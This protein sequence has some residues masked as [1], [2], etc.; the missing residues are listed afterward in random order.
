MITPR[1]R[2]SAIAFSGIFCR[3]IGSVLN[4]VAL[5]MGVTMSLDRIMQAP[6]RLI[7][8]PQHVYQ[9]KQNEFARV[10]AGAVASALSLTGGAGELFDTLKN[11]GVITPDSPLWYLVDGASI[12]NY[13]S[14]GDPHADPAA[15]GGHRLTRTER[16]FSWTAARLQALGQW[17]YTNGA[18]LAGAVY[19]VF[20]SLPIVQVRTHPRNLVMSA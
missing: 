5:G 6:M 7:H 3:P 15:N 10:I 9:A 4:G 1:G 19:A 12:L 17:V 18:T 2:C 20:N 13:P 14:A 8:A 16:L 11:P